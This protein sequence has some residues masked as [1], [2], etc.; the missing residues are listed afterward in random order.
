MTR[1]KTK[2]HWGR[3]LRYTFAAALCLLMPAVIHAGLQWYWAVIV[4]C[5]AFLLVVS[6]RQIFR[7]GI[8][9]TANEVVC[10]YVPWYEGTAYFLCLALPLMGVAAIAAGREPGNPARILFVGFVLLA[11]M[12]IILWSVVQLRRRSLL[13]ISPSA[14]TLRLA[15]PGSKLTEIRREHVESITSKMVRNPV[16]GQSLQTEI[17]YRAADSNNADIQTVLLGLHLSV[18]PIN[19]ANALVAWNDGAEE[20]PDELLDRIEQTLRGQS[21]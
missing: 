15:T 3:A 13:C 1:T 19:L 9:R 18:Q 11:A 14:L 17:A 8:S 21:N 5:L 4:L 7:P 10:R 6:Q 16:N 2:I 12:P 20:D